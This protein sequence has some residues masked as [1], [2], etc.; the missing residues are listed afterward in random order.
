[1]PKFR[2]VQEMMNAFSYEGK[3]DAK[4]KAMIDDSRRIGLYFYE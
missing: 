4:R 1:M 3:A 2:S